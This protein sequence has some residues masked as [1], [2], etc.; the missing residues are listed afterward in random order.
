MQRFSGAT[1][2]GT[3][4][5]NAQS[6]RSL[7]DCLGLPKYAHVLEPMEQ[8][9]AAASSSKCGLDGPSSSALPNKCS[10][11]VE[12]EEVHDLHDPFYNDSDSEYQERIALN[13]ID[14][15]LRTE[16]MSEA[17]VDMDI[18]NSAGFDDDASALPQS[19]FPH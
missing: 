17:N 9:Y 6:T 15:S 3:V 2:C 5:E 7:A 4:Y 1:T 16:I 19:F 12:V 8:G 14:A 13:A 18:A 10:K 11:S